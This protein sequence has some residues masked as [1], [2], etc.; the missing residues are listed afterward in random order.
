M[1][2]QGPCRCSLCRCQVPRNA[3]TGDILPGLDG[4]QERDSILRNLEV[5][6]ESYNAEAIDEVEELSPDV[7]AAQEARA[8]G[9]EHYLCMSEA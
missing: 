1:H 9:M 3:A 4:L 5:N 7:A 8:T 2:I 6:E